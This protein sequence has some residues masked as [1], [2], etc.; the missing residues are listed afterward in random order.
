MIRSMKPRSSLRTCV[1][2][3]VFLGALGGSAGAQAQEAPSATA[4]NAGASEDRMAEARR[5]FEAGVSLLEDPDGAKYEDAYRAFKKAYE[6]SQSPKVLGNIAFCA[7]H[8]ERDGEAVDSYTT[9]LRDVPDVSERERVQIQRD[10]A[11]MMATMARV[12]VVVKTPTAGS[13]VVDRRT[14]TRGLVVENAYPLE[15]TEL[16][17]RLRPGRHT[18]F[19]RTGATESAAFDATLEPG[20][21]INFAPQEQA[22][23]EER[24]GPALTGRPITGPIVV[25]AVGLVAIG[26]GIAT[27]IVARGKTND[28]E[29]SCPSNLCPTSYNLADARTSAKTF[30]TVADISFIGGGALVGGALLWYLLSPQGSASPKTTGSTAS[31]KSSWRPTAMCTRDGCGF[32]MGRGF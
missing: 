18:L 12:R 3:A 5:Q 28:I 23:K 9:Y 7:L 20:S 29:K 22:R 10:L 2:A 26:V 11:T 21:Q 24:P 8:L 4:P 1:C 14:Q 25:G 13:I 15:S 19:V 30:G 31:W 16:V 17:L 32:N 27:G 6:L